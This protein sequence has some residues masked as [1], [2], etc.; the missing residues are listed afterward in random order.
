M[1]RKN[2]CVMLYKKLFVNDAKFFGKMEDYAYDRAA[3]I[4]S[5]KKLAINGEKTIIMKNGQIPENFGL[6]DVDRIEI[7]IKAVTDSYQVRL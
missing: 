6:T 1:E 2:R 5:A 4:F 3:I 7:K